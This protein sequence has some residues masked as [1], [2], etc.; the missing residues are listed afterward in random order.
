LSEGNRTSDILDR[1][2]P[3]YDRRI[4]YGPD[5]LNFADLRIPRGRGPFPLLLIIHGGFWQSAYDLEHTGLLCADLTGRG[6]VTCNLEYRRIGNPGGGWPGTFQDISLASYRIPEILNSDPRVDLTRTAVMGH[7]AG[8][9]L[10]LWLVSRHKISKSSPLH[11]S[12]KSP[13]V[14]AISL[15]GVADLRSAWKERLGHGIVTRLMDGPP[16]QHPDRYDAGSPI[17]LLPNG[18][19]QVLI[20]GAVDNT[21][22]MSQ[23]EQFERKAAESGDKC[24]LVKLAD[25]GHF[26]LIDP[27]SDA[28]SSVVTSVETMLGVNRSRTL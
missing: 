17:E 12:R 26:E 23:S 13:I 24:S 5:P 8:G 19:R 16:D 10:A 18:A 3:P 21:V 2:P 22:P 11:E 4:K 9:H 15:A 1:R 25:T 7:S 20:H 6:I 28:W 27:E 14:N